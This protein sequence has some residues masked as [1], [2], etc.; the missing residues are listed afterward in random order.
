MKKDKL[1]K[2][3]IKELIKQGVPGYDQVVYQLIKSGE[4]EEAYYYVDKKMDYIIKKLLDMSDE[5]LSLLAYIEAMI[6]DYQLIKAALDNLYENGDV[7][8]DEKHLDL[9]GTL[10][11]A[12]YHKNKNHNRRYKAL[13]KQALKFKPD[14]NHCGADEYLLIQAK[15]LLEE[16]K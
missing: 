8:I 6:G 4:F 16:V 7:M 9:Y 13:L 3:E 5:D 14:E 2:K 10:A 1:T 12:L 15:S 11:S